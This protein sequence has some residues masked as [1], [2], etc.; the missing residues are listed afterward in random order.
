MIY[1]MSCLEIRFCDVLGVEEKNFY[2]KLETRTHVRDYFRCVSLRFILHGLFLM[3]AINF[4]FS[5]TS[6]ISR[7]ISP[8]DMDSS[9]SSESELESEELEAK[10]GARL[11]EQRLCTLRQNF[12]LCTKILRFNLFNVLFEKGKCTLINI[13][14]NENAPKLAE[15]LVSLCSPFACLPAL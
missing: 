4:F 14:L 10:R 13:Q 3:V 2:P 1:L 11:L 9:S 5:S 12:H 8:S 6:S 15:R 7:A